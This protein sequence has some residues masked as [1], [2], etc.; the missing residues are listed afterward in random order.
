MEPRSDSADGPNGSDPN[1][2]GRPSGPTRATHGAAVPKPVDNEVRGPTEPPG[3]MVPG[4]SPRRLMPAPPRAP[5]RWVTAS[6]TGDEALAATKPPDRPM[7]R[8]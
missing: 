3:D 6:C 2:S 8:G 7:R 5:F 1:G 4:G